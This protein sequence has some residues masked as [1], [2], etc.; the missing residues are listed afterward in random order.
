MYEK[1]NSILCVSPRRLQPAKQ[2]WLKALSFLSVPLPH[3]QQHALSFLF[4]GSCHFNSHTPFNINLWFST[5]I[6]RT[7]IPR[8]EI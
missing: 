4:L 2:H 1:Y 6:E 8:S 3:T 5:I 7:C